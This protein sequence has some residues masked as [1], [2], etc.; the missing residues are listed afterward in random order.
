[1]DASHKEIS[2]IFKLDFMLH[3]SAKIY[4]ILMIDKYHEYHNH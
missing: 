2:R 3:Q 1:M 4:E